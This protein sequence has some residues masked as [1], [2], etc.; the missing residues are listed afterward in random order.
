MLHHAEQQALLRLARLDGRARFAPLAQ[1]LAPVDA[2]AALA[3][4]G[5][6]A[7]LAMRRQD[8]PDLR[9]EELPAR[10]LSRLPVIG[11]HGRAERQHH[12]QQSSRANR[13]KPCSEMSEVHGALFYRIPLP[14][15]VVAASAALLRVFGRREERLKPPPGKAE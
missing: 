9:L 6:V 11:P 5:A 2:Q 4:L 7:G 10:G 3:L 1:G 12:A 13:Y 14:Y 8:R 15:T